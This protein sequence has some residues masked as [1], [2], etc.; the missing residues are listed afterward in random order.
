MDEN[1]PTEKKYRYVYC[2]TEKPGL[3]KAIWTKL[4]IAMVNQD[5]SINLYLDAVPLSG[6]LQI[7]ERDDDGRRW[8]NRD[9]HEPAPSSP[10]SFDF[11]GSI[12]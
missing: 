6:K 12:Q 10:P 8:S 1:K 3:K 4:G 2:I 5:Q 7:R 11:G 9:Q